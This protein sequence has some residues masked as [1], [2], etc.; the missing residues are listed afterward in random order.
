[1]NTIRIIL[2]IY[3]LYVYSSTWFS[4]YF[5]RK[6]KIYRIL[7]ISINKLKNRELLIESIINSTYVEDILDNNPHI[8]MTFIDK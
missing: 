2:I 3:T 1:M 4:N 5:V 7:E 8:L 6:N